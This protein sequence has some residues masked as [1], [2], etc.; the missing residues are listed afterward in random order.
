MTTS[1]L[2]LQVISKEKY[3][4]LL[5]QYAVFSRISHAVLGAKN[6]T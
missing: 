1:R 3:A 4:A 2:T 5:E 6:F